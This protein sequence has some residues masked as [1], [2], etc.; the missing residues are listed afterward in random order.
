MWQAIIIVAIT[1]YLLRLSPIFY[2]PLRQLKKESRV[3]KFFDYSICLIT[4]EL[5]YSIAFESQAISLTLT[6]YISIITLVSI[7]VAGILTAI[8]KSTIKSFI[9]SLITFI[10]LLFALNLQIN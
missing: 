10:S 7:L 8:T 2:P 6:N 9:I 5:I 1:T 3:Y 4:G